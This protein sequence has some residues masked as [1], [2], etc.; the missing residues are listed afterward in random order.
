[1]AAPATTGNA[2]FE[3]HHRV[4]MNTLEQLIV[5]LP[6]LYGFAVFVSSLWAAVLGAVFVVGR[7]LYYAFYLEDPAKRG[8]GMLL[9]LVPNVALVVGALVGASLALA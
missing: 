8:P 3:R 5:F 2:M 7:A 9:S 1:V 6:A 4:Q